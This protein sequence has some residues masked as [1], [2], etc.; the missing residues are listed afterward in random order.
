MCNRGGVLILCDL[1]G[2]LV[3]G[4]DAISR[5]AANLAQEHRQ[6]EDFAEWV[7]NEYASGAWERKELFASVRDRLAIATPLD[8]LSGAFFEGVLDSFR[9]T[10]ETTAALRALRAAGHAIAIVSNG[11]PTQMRKIEAA[12]LTPLVDAV[13]ISSLEG[14]SKPDPA[15]LG[16]RCQEVRSVAQRRMDDRRLTRIGHRRSGCGRNR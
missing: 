9:C 7:L 16:D 13:C 8:E 14:C 12:A 10:T 2:T 6:D 1:D 11:E 5:W 4:V 3:S 15:T